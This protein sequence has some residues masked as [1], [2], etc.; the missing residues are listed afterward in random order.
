MGPNSLR[1]FMRLLDDLTPCLLVIYLAWAL[2]LQHYWLPYMDGISE[3]SDSSSTGAEIGVGLA[4]I[5][6]IVLG[7]TA[8]IYCC[9]VRQ[10]GGTET[11]SASHW[12]SNIDGNMYTAEPFKSSRQNS[13]RLPSKHE[14]TTSPTNE[15]QQHQ[16]YESIDLNSGVNPSASVPVE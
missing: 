14:T 12:K 7:I 16:H 10:C 1:D 2:H 11:K 15:Q 4:F 13:K 8:C 9:C 5:I 3:E 6:I